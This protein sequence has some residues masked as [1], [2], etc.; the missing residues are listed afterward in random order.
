MQNSSS[1]IKLQVYVS[2]LTGPLWHMKKLVSNYFRS[3][4]IF[5][6]QVVN[7]NKLSS[8]TDWYLNPSIKFDQNPSLAA[9]KTPHSMMAPP[10]YQTACVQERCTVFFCSTKYCTC[11]SKSYFLVSS[12]PPSI[13]YSDFLFAL[14]HK[15]LWSIR[16]KLILRTFSYLSCGSLQLFKSCKLLLACQVRWTWPLLGLY[17]NDSLSLSD[18]SFE[19]V[20]WDLQ[21]VEFSLAMWPC[22]KLYLNDVVCS[23]IVFSI[24]L[25]PGWIIYILRHFKGKNV[26]HTF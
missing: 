5:K 8:K 19:N 23:P 10:P 12:F 18:E 21:S 3:Q 2:A 14:L 6:S 17:L 16:F 22:F 11:W 9:E 25:R 4:R 13:V 15:D 20:Q 1:S 7:N 26:Q 24:H